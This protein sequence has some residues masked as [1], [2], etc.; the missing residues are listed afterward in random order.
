[1]KFLI[2]SGR[3][4]S[5]W[6]PDGKG[7]TKTQAMAGQYTIE[8][9]KRQR[10]DLVGPGDATPA[11]ADVLVP[12]S[13]GKGFCTTVTLAVPFI[14]VERLLREV[15]EDPNVANKRL[16]LSRILEDKHMCQTALALLRESR[17]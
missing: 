2:W 15:I 7:Y 12:I 14:E 13:E 5:W 9:L 4:K 8:D 1:M 6:M 16:I 10:L 17:V 3:H 11:H